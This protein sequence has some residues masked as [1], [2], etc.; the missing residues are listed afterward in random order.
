LECYFNPKLYQ[1]DT[2][3][4]IPFDNFADFMEKFI[5]KYLDSKNPIVT[6][7]GS[8]V[9]LNVS[10]DINAWVAAMLTDLEKAWDAREAER[11]NDPA[12]VKID[13]FR[14]ALNAADGNQK[15]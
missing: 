1:K 2:E 6:P 8:R 10:G 12:R 4:S 11:K 13:E 3:N 9:N 14:A 5:E 15:T 7:P